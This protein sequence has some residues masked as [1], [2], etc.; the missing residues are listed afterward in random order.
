MFKTKY[1]K[2]YNKYLKLLELN[3]GSEPE[4]INKSDCNYTN[5]TV[6][7][8]EEI[9]LEINEFKETLDILNGINIEEYQ[10]LVIIFGGQCY[11]L[12]TE[13]CYQLRKLDEIKKRAEKGFKSLVLIIDVFNDSSIETYSE[14]LKSIENNIDVQHLKMGISLNPKCIYNIIL[15]NFVENIV[16]KKGLVIIIQSA[17]FIRELDKIIKSINDSSNIIKSIFKEEYLK[18]P[19]VIV[20]VPLNFD[21]ITDIIY[22][23]VYLKALDNFS[24]EFGYSIKDI[25]FQLFELEKED[26]KALKKLF[27]KITFDF[28]SKI[29]INLLNHIINYKLL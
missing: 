10:N 26:R 15:N 13:Y 21:I 20:T 11:E 27:G 5:F 3:G 29:N 6:T 1:Q 14:T 8:I 24:K 4:V 28:G 18:L 2:Y 7:P 23:N 16:N 22:F 9:I 25:L 12:N 19:N 17:I